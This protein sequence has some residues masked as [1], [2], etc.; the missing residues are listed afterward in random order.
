MM[1]ASD[2]VARMCNHGYDE[3]AVERKVRSFQRYWYRHCA[4]LGRWSYFIEQFPALV[5]RRRYELAAPSI[6]APAHTPP[7]KNRG[8]RSPSPS[9]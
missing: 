1:P 4:H 6:P 5:R 7:A 3:R 9:S 2:L 8:A